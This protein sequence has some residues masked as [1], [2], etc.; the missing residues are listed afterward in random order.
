MARSETRHDSRSI[1]HSVESLAAMHPHSTQ[2]FETMPSIL[3]DANEERNEAV[4]SASAV[5]RLMRGVTAMVWYGMVVIVLINFSYGLLTGAPMSARTLVTPHQI[6]ARVDTLHGWITRNTSS[7]ESRSDVHAKPESTRYPSM[8]EAPALYALHF[9]EAASRFGVE[10]AL[11]KAIAR[12]ESNGMPHAVSHKGALG[13]MQLMLPTARDYLDVGRNDLFNPRVN[14]TISARHLA[15]LEPRVKR[16][17]ALANYSD[18]VR[19][20]LIAAAYNAGWSR[21]K[22]YRGIP[23]FPETQT[24]SKRVWRYYEALSESSDSVL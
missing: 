19:V 11:L 23:P 24:Y 14:I 6:D 9:Q 7:P 2:F 8:R 16:M 12:A 3:P 21:V 20:K 5:H 4:P 17:F 13:V 1:G 22:Q 15:G 10:L 18:E